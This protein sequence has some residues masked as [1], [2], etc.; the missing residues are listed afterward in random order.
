MQNTL[1]TQ[2]VPPAR[3]AEFWPEI[4]ESVL[5]ACMLR[6]EGR[7]SEAIAILQNKLPPLIGRWSRGAGLPAEYCQ[8]VLRELF[9]RVQQQVATAA[10]CKRF[11]LRSV[12]PGV[13]RPSAVPQ[14]VEVRRR[15]PIDDIPGMLDALDEGER[16]AM[17]R[18]N[19][20]PTTTV[21]AQ[22]VLAAG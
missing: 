17:L 8:Q 13:A 5:E 22:P 15:V 18:R 9:A 14:P 19:I 10:I 11:V 4:E 6:A 3:S 7:E 2:T 1:T 12:I 20:F 16:V 21:R